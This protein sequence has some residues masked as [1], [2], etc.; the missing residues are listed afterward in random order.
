MGVGAESSL[1]LSSVDEGLDWLAGS[2]FYTFPK[3]HTYSN[4]IY[5]TARTREAATVCAL[6]PRVW[7]AE[8]EENTLEG[9][10]H[11]RS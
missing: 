3:A 9:R 1:L 5:T 2:P 10:R 7:N 6:P 8:R 4:Y 11:R